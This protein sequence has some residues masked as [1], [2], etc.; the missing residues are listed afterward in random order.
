M[1]SDFRHDMQT[2]ATGSGDDPFARRPFQFTLRTL[3]LLTLVVALFCS[4]AVTF[5][6]IARFL[7]IATVAWAG[8]GAI[9]WKVRVALAAVLAHVFCPI[10]VAIV[11]G[12]SAWQEHVVENSLDAWQP[13]FGI[14]FVVGSVISVGIACAIRFQ[15]RW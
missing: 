2:D 13:A 10:Y 5:G 8:V 4:A 15:Q 12:V 11:V 3:L 1:T 14:G 9:Y 7:A 6:G